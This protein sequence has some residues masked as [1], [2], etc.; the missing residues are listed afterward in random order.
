MYYVCENLVKPLTEPSKLSWAEL[1][2]STEMQWFVSHY[3]GMPARH[4]GEAIRKH[5]QSAAASR[6]DDWGDSAY[7]ICTFSNSQWHVTDELGNGHWQ[8]RIGG[9]W[10]LVMLV[11]IHLTQSD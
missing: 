9:C 1:V 2:G 6:S 5:A 10:W 3:W 4:L 8:E 7:W 11:Q